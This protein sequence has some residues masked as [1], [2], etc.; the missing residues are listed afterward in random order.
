MLSNSVL[1]R[2][3]ASPPQGSG[4][5]NAR[6]GCFYIRNI[7]VEAHSLDRVARMLLRGPEEPHS[8]AG[9]PLHTWMPRTAYGSIPSSNST[10]TLGA[11]PT[12]RLQSERQASL[13]GTRF[14]GHPQSGVAANS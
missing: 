14:G 7:T 13:E 10:M 3:C 8:A 4:D 1:R 9:P 11:T 6:N 12:K 5:P 2:S